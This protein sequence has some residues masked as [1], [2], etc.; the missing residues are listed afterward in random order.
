MDLKSET[1]KL[2]YETET[3]SQIQRTL[4]VVKRE[5]DG[6]GVN[7]EFGITDTNHYRYYV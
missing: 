3:D 5:E 2:T 1:N 4:V 6:E 7:W